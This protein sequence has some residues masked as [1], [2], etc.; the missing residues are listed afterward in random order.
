MKQTILALW[1]GILSPYEHC[2][3]DDSEANDLTVLMDRHYDTLQKELSPTQMDTVEKLSACFD[4]YLLRMQEHAFS[5]GFS[6]AA[7]MLCEA[8][9]D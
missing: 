8:L 1:N 5:D 3:S 6:L 2:G 7:K 4:E 9:S